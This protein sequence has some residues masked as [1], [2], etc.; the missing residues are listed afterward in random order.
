MNGD[1]SYESEVYYWLSYVE[2]LKK[3]N[4]RKKHY[5]III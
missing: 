4:E 3:Y 2:G 1:I 5:Y